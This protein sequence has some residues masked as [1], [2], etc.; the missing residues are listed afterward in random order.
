MSTLAHPPMRSSRPA[1]G[2]PWVPRDFFQ[3]FVHTPRALRLVWNT[4]PRLTIVLIGLTLVAGLLPAAI[5]WV[6]K[7]IVDAVVAA[8]RGGDREPA[9]R[10]VAIEGVLVVLMLAAQRGL[11]TCQSLL[12]ALLGH[13][14][15]VLILDKALQMSLPQFEDA[16]T[17]D[18][19]T[20][21][22]REAS[23][24]PLSLV[25]R[26]FGLGQNAISLASYAVLLVAFSPWAVV[27]LVLA[28]LPAFLAEARFSGEA[29]RLFR[30]RS[31]ETRQQSYLEVLIARE[32][33]AKE[34][35][36]FQLGP[37]LL[38]RYVAIF[39]K[40]FAE[41]RALTWSRNLWGFVLG[42]GGTLALYGAFA[43]TVWSAVRGVLS[44]G[45]MTLYM[46][47]FRQGQSA[48]A[49][50]LSAIGGMYEDNLYLSTLFELLD[51]PTPTPTGTARVGPDPADGVR[52]EAVSFCYP[53]ASL[54]A[55]EAVSL[56]VRPGE[57]LALV[58]ANGSGKTTLIKLLTRLYEPT[59]GRI[60]L[61][62]LDL[63]QWDIHLLRQRIGVIFQDFVHYQLLAGE[64][65]GAGDVRHFG[66]QARWHEAAHKGMADT[67]LE[68][69]PKGYHTQLG[70]W[71]EDGRELSGGQ[72]QRIALARAFMR[73]DAAILV[74]DE[75]TSA[76]DAAAEAEIFDRLQA[77]AE[78]RMCILISHRFSTVRRADR[79]AVLE[80]GRIIEEGDHAA[81]V[82]HGGVYARLFEVQAAG[83][84]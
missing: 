29:F 73:Q 21:A 31:P 58:G 75:P 26:L 60:T 5:A 70:R 54:P 6:G 53:G 55:V 34:V 16:N 14:V 42:L 39:E 74:L 63:R 59:A 50:C 77:Q 2:S 68:S 81:L 30:W 41:D 17:Y 56:H 10:Y 66:D 82:A 1:S 12:R 32:D 20:R 61:D 22:R 13:R 67:F 28:G 78:G 19:L 25:M 62:G 37:L 51:A 71:F 9:L 4:A 27:V 79:I 46:L 43:W 23:T 65:I 33:T 18:Q 38:Q 3:V 7:S 80:Q 57:T 45:G 8:G 40:V 24:R 84:R 64:N 83:Y 72:W 52:F 48:V 15:N 76:M 49:A 35:T 47:L 36:V 11:S 44:L 69:L